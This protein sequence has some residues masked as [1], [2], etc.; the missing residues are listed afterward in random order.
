MSISIL[1]KEIRLEIWALAYLN[2]PPRL[3]ALE[4][5]SH[6]EDHDEQHFCPR[7]S[8]SPRPTVVNIC[9]EARAEARYQAIRAKHVV[10]LPA[11][12]TGTNCDEFYFRVDT[13]MLLLQLEGPRV[14]H[15]DDSPNAGLLAHFSAATGCDFQALENVALTKV[16]SRGFRDDSLFNVLRAFPRISRIIMLLPDDVWNNDRQKELFVREAASKYTQVRG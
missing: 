6:D 16:V 10:Q 4:T 15:Y 11:S 14:R 12:L 8:P 5:K 1:P 9:H 3:V 2:E 13:D 7:Y